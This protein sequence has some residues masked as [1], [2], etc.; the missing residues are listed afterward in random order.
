MPKIRLYTKHQIANSRTLLCD[1]EEIDLNKS[2]G[3]SRRAWHDPSRT[4]IHANPPDKDEQAAVLL[5]YTSYGLSDDCDS[6]F[7]EQP[8]LDRWQARVSDCT[9]NL[10]GRALN[11]RD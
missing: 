9:R 1:R 8:R 6:F 2:Y 5:D 4:W 11:F 10:E 7:R 3:E